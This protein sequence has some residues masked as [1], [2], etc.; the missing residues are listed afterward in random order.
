MPNVQNGFSRST[1]SRNMPKN[2]TL[3]KSEC[4]F[5]FLQSSPEETVVM[6]HCL[7]PRLPWAQT[8]WNSLGL[9]IKPRDVFLIFSYPVQSS[10]WP[11]VEPDVVFCFCGP[12]NSGF[13]ALCILSCFSAYHRCS[14]C[15]F[16]LAYLSW[17][18]QQCYMS[19]KVWGCLEWIREYYDYDSWE[20][21]AWGLHEGT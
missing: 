3:Q 11:G 1:A 12:S 17:K 7:R 14:E 2:S 19:W 5:R 18:G 6:R 16:E 8:H 10:L 13:H 9:K 4:R 15:F 20:R 21:V